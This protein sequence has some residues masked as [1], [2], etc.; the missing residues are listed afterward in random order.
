MSSVGWRPTRVDTWAMARPVGQ[1]LE[2]RQLA[3]VDLVPADPGQRDDQHPVDGLGGHLLAVAAAG[4][5]EP[6]ER[7]RGRPRIDA[8][9]GNGLRHL[10]GCARDR[11][12]HGER[13]GYPEQAVAGDDDA[14]TDQ[15][16]SRRRRHDRRARGRRR[17][18]R[19]SAGRPTPRRRPSSR[20]RRSGPRPR[21]RGAPAAGG[22][23]GHRAR[24][25]RRVYAAEWPM[26]ERGHPG[27]ALGERRPRRPSPPRR[28]PRADQRHDARGAAVAQ[29][30]V[31]RGPAAER[32]CRGTARRPARPPP[33][34]ASATPSPSVAPVDTARMPGRARAIIP[35]VTGTTS[36]A[37]RSRAHRMDAA[38]TSSPPSRASITRSGRIAVWIGWAST[39]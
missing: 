3:V 11:K 4:E 34:P 26:S 19:S 29:G 14:G 39:P 10:G 2:G 22:P 38:K 32:R 21:E 37:I 27:G 25:H 28:P 6:G 23:A 18:G 36:R 24:R 1:R 31:A 7:D 17:P 16:R 20:W 33:R 12:P 35:A 9:H 5:C 30:V 13:T 15:R 8:S